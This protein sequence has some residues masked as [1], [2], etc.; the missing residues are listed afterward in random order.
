MEKRKSL[1]H[2]GKCNQK[3]KRTMVENLLLLNNV[4]LNTVIIEANISLDFPV[5]FSSHF[6][7]HS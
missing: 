6:S 7:F 1:R 2:R 4:L 5:L 3:I